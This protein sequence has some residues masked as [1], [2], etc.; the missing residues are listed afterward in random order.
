MA[1]YGPFEAYRMNSKFRATRKNSLCVAILDNDLLNGT[2]HHPT[3]LPIDIYFLTELVASFGT[4]RRMDGGMHR[5]SERRRYP[6]A[7]MATEG[8]LWIQ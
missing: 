7:P 8:K 5:R 3:K 6:S 2:V 1:E 4:D